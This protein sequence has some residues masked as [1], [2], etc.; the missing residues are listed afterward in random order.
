MEY[1]ADREN[2]TWK[3]IEKRY[4]LYESDPHFATLRKEQIGK[5]LSVPGY[6]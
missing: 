6:I 2:R 4:K 3:K 5:L 1:Y